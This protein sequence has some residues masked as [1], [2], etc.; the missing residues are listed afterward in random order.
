MSFLVSYDKINGPLGVTMII[1]LS[2][3][4]SNNLIF[5]R[6]MD[7]QVPLYHA[8]YKFRHPLAIY[9]V[10]NALVI[11]NFTKTIDSL[12]QVI[13]EKT[14]LIT[15]QKDGSRA[16][17]ENL[18]SN[19]KDLLYALMETLEGYENILACFFPSKD[20][21]NKNAIVREYKKSAEEYR[22]HIGKIV[23]YIKHGQ[24]RLRSITFYNENFV[25][26]GYFVEG[27]M[28]EGEVGPHI[29]I[30]PDGNSAFSFTRDL[31]YNLFN[32]YALRVHLNKAIKY[33]IGES[34][35]LDP[36]NKLQSDESVFEISSKISNLPMIFYP[37][38]ALK[39]VPSVSILQKEENET[40]IVLKY[41]D[42][43]GKVSTIQKGTKIMT[44]YISDGV[45]RSFR[46]PYAGK[47]I[48]QV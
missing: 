28:T 2:N 33:L 46:T 36:M 39:P 18:I 45:T 15:S 25:L 24:G 30:H 17:I 38:E 44:E 1:S 4:Q 10:S 8:N 26:P 19:Q 43:D 42:E 11:N 13:E 37:D 20:I 34:C 14:F 12:Y 27:P 21:R 6:L 3:K 9:N 40:V 31:R 29:E 48:K 16:A 32:F 22:D 7:F 35:Q 23:N 41:P 5:D 47:S